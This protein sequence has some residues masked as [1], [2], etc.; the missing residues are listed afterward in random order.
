M[1]ELDGQWVG[2]R[3]R[4][5]RRAAD[6]QARTYIVKVPE[7]SSDSLC[8]FVGADGRNACA[9]HS[10]S[11]EAELWYVCPA[12]PSG[13]SYSEC[14]WTL[15]ASIGGLAG[16]I[17]WSD[18]ITSRSRGDWYRY[19]LKEIHGRLQLFATNKESAR[20]L[21][22]PSAVLSY[23]SRLPCVR[24]IP[25]KAPFKSVVHEFLYRLPRQHA[26]DVLCEK[27]RRVHG[28]TSHYACK[29]SRLAFRLAF[30]LQPNH[31]ISVN[32]NRFSSQVRSHR[33]L[34]LASTDYRPS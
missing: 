24:D 15:Y 9:S 7:I 8:L 1:E 4:N 33:P 13:Q 32:L 27:N 18:D 12:W 21:V 29:A 16:R 17:K 10:A 11:D 2:R 31:E 6:P 23:L 20:G 3:R 14:K 34:Y 28:L 19:R 22:Q 26:D 5:R 25:I 30:D